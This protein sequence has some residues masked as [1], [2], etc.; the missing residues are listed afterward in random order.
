MLVVMLLVLYLKWVLMMY[1]LST[2]CGFYLRRTLCTV[3]WHNNST[4]LVLVQY[5]VM[6]TSHHTLI[7]AQRIHMRGNY[8]SYIVCVCVCVCVL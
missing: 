4:T 2:A 8:N 5:T 3:M 1:T 6:L 7:N